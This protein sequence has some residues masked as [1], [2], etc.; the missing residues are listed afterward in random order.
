VVVAS[1]TDSN[2]A[3]VAADFTATIDLGR[4]DELGGY[5]SGSGGHSTFRFAHLRDGRADTLTVT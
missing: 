4:R 5:V 3:N 1:F 2:T